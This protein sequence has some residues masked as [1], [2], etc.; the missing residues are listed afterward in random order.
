MKLFYNRPS[1]YARKVLVTVHEKE[2][3]GGVTLL[4]VDPWSDPP[5]LLAATPIGKV[6]ALIR[7]DG[8][9]VVGSATICAYLER[10]GGT[11]PA[12]AEERDDMAARV[13]LVDGMIDAAFTAVI[14]GRRPERHRWADWIARQR[15]VIGRTLPVIALPPPGRF[16]QGDIALASALAYLDFRLGDFGWRD[17]YP[18]LA[19]WLDAAEERPSMRETRP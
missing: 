1:P 11:E 8:R 2:L 15:R 13:S 14:E 5:D 18:A 12:T 3:I 4:E 19:S 10:L 16:D 17:D 6:P 9:L 7:D